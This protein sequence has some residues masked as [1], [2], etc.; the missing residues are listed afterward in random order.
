VRNRC[1]P[2]VTSGSRGRP[3]PCDSNP[4]WTWRACKGCSRPCWR[5]RYG[6][7]LGRSRRISWMVFATATVP[8]W[9]AGRAVIAKG[10]PRRSFRSLPST[11]PR[12]WENMPRWTTP[13]S[14]VG[15]GMFDLRATA[16]Q[17][18]DRPEFNPARA[19]AIT[20]RGL[21]TATPP[22]YVT[23]EEAYEFFTTHFRLKPEEQDL[24]RRLLLDGKIKG[25]YL[26]M[27]ALTDVLETDPDRRL[28]RFL[29]FGRAT[30]VAA[31]SRGLAGAGVD[32]AQLAG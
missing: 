6:W 31:A 26:G 32:G 30:A 25:R 11:A 29:K 19:V 21:G 17:L 13:W 7:M 22:L 4:C 16:T 2:C 24:Y 20:L 10:L 8:P 15:S 14:Q 3:I 18:L 27:D 28:A 23:Q 12:Y 5:T 1:G 9:T